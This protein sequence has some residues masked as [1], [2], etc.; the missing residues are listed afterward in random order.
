MAEKAYNGIVSGYRFQQSYI[1][2]SVFKII[3]KNCLLLECYIHRYTNDSKINYYCDYIFDIDLKF[4]LS[5]LVNFV[6]NYCP[7]NCTVINVFKMY[8]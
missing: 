2:I 4:K 8:L 5:K 3:E 6:H 7:L 1:F